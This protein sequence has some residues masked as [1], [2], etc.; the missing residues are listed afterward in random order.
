MAVAKEY[1]DEQLNYYKIC[2]VTTDILTAGLRTIFKQEWDSRYGA[3]LG[4]WK[5]DPSNGKDFYSKESPRNQRRNKHMLS[6]MIKGNRAEWDSTMLFYAILYSDCIYNLNAVVRTNV[7]DLRKFRNEEFAHM[8][9]GQ[10]SELEFKNAIGKVFA[11]FQALGLSTV[12]IQEITNQKTFPTEEV[13][14]LLDKVKALKKDLDRKVLSEQLLNDTSS[15]CI[16]PPKPLH[17]IAS[18]DVEVADITNQLQE[19]KRADVSNLSILYISGNPG[20]GKSQLASLVAERFY[21]K[22]QEDTC[23][24]V[25]VMTLNAETLGTL[26]DSYITF[27]RQMKCPED[28]ITQI[29]ISKDLKTEDKINSLISLI[30]SKIG[31]YESWLLLADNVKSLSEIHFHL[32][33]QR[34]GQW[35]RGYLL[36][37]T[38]DSP[39]IPLTSTSIRHISVSEG[40]QSQE[41]CSLLA[42]ISGISDSEIGELVAKEL[43]YQP[44]ALANAAT[45]VKQLRQSK[46]F[47]EFGW[48]DFLRKVEKGQRDATETLLTETNP[49]YK[50]SMTTA[51]TLAVKEVM[52][53]DRII[54]HALSFLSLLSSQPLN[55]DIV[56]NYIVSV[57]EG[58]KDEEM[59]IMKLQRCSLI[60]THE[61]EFGSHIRVHQVVRD[62]VKS[63]I[64]CHPES[65]LKKTFNSAVAAFNQFIDDKL[66]KESSDSILQSYALALHLKYFI[67]SF[68]NVL[69]KI[70]L[71]QIV[72]PEMEKLGKICENHCH[73]LAAKKFYE[74]LLQF[75]QKFGIEHTNIATSYSNLGVV[76]HK[77][78]DFEKAKEYHEL[79]LSITQKKLGPE[80][81]QVATSYNNLGSVHEQLGDFEKAKEYHQLALSITQKKLGPENVQVA[82]SY[83]NF[84]LVHHKL[85]DFEK[86]KVY[87]ELALSITQKKL[88]PENV[89]VATIYNNLGLVHEQLGEFEKAKEYHELALRI[90]MKKLGPENVSVATSYNNL[91]LVHDKLGNLEKAREYHKLALGIKQ[92]KL[93]PENVEVASSYNNLGSVHEQL[94]DFE[95]AKEYHERALSITQK[96]LGPENVSVATSYN[97]LG[98][99]HEQLGDF[100]KAKEY[101]ELALS[102]EMKKLGPENVE[103]ATSYN[104]LGLVYEQ[105]GDFEK[106]K[107]YHQL[108]L[109]IKQKKLGPENVEVATSYNNLGLVHHN[110]GDFEKAKEYHELALSITQ[111]KLGPENVSVATSY[112]NLGLVHDKLG[113]FEKAKGYHELALSITQKKL[114]PENVQ[115]ATSYNNLGCVHEQLG[116]FEKAKEYHQLALS[117]TQKKLG[118]ENVQVATSYNNLGLVYEQL[119][120]FEKAK[121]YH[122]IALSITQ[123]K[124]G[125]ENVQVATSYNNLGLVNEKLGDFEKAKEYHELALSIKQKKLG[126]E[127]VSVATS[128]NNLGSVHHKLGD[129]EKAKEYHKLALS[130]TQKKL[131]PENVQVAASYN[132]L[133]LVPVKTG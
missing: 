45:Y 22:A 6:T 30:S 63:L 27:A 57:D 19:L 121:E 21:E 78:G 44:L 104:N 16:L 127:N 3:T 131:G 26:L 82:T 81:V 25:F 106:A 28:A 126:P 31:K 92:E 119:G 2:H 116:D 97:N 99:V 69:S 129:F 52:Q 79:A 35:G 39:C 14:D 49:C 112:N 109:S 47:S 23:S 71:S 10:L 87:H 38:Q 50:K 34:H 84:G 117:I 29:H 51:T 108:S 46:R 48:N 95:K 91:G 8:P 42:L 36:I 9:Q 125:A 56:V 60:L 103:V 11:A 12:E 124:L 55:V 114:E 17:D 80:N 115:M 7:D 13:R 62:V 1:T 67:L 24:E 86:A 88:G 68:E 77:L 73:F 40:M 20:S 65:R 105:L 101:H 43:D 66:P 58:I 120:N 4:E 94:G 107:E 54:D 130:I 59:I 53:S 111:K 89:R 5:D 74:F 64:K 72:L 110:L 61:D 18:R 98:L 85:G 118:P 123:K 33:Q 93:G 128:Y 37:T 83:N 70:V 75:L 32:P 90:E 102:I 133:G 41:A 96:K 122:K 76:H 132:N 113:D 100:E 15:F